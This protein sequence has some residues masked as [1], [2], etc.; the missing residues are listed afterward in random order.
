MKKRLDII[1]FA[2]MKVTFREDDLRGVYMH[3]SYVSIYLYLSGFRIRIFFADPDPG[4]N[5]H[6][7]L[8]LVPG[9]PGEG[10]GG[11]GKK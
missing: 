7:D 4:K 2:S 3:D 5:F 9:Y 10:A 8:D 6:V 11:K 1:I